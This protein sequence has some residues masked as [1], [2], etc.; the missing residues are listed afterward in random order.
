MSQA[1]WKSK[2]NDIIN[3]CQQE[4]KK[5]TQIGSKMLSASQSNSKLCESYEELG[6]LVC[7]SVDNGDL[8]WENERAQELMGI[9]ST[10]E[11]ELASL[12]ED[13]QNIKKE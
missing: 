10:T 1:D 4:L 5:T 7:K 2:I 9:I 3:T 6:R 8:G 12:E 13:V 11:K